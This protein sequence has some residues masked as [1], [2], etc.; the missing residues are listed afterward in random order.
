MPALR[1]T[2]QLLSN[3]L[4]A[5][6]RPVPGCHALEKR[7][8]ANFADRPQAELERRAVKRTPNGALD[9]EATLSVAEKQTS[10]G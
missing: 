1:R 6:N 10:N 8:L 4:T 3:E 9:P 2:E 7:T 5:S